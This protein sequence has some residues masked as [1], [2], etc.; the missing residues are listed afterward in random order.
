MTI[1]STEF[2]QRVGYYL[3][4]ME[5]GMELILEKKKPGKKYL[6]LSMK[7]LPGN[8]DEN[9]GRKKRFLNEIRKIPWEHK[10]EDC[11]SFQNRV[12]R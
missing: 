4:L 5:K 9:V 8:D 10:G 7:I 6:V 3:S 2:Q 12:R 1:S 11:I